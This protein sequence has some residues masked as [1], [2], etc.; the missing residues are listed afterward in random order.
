MNHFPTSSRFSSC[1]PWSL[2][3]KLSFR[4][5]VKN[6]YNTSS[7]HTSRHKSSKPDTDSAL[8]HAETCRLG[9]MTFLSLSLSE[10]IFVSHFGRAE[11]MEEWGLEGWAFCGGSGK[12]S[13]ACTFSKPILRV[14]S[15]EMFYYANSNMWKT[16]KEDNQDTP[17]FRL[18]VNLLQKYGR[19]PPGKQKLLKSDVSPLELVHESSLAFSFV[20]FVVVVMEREFWQKSCLSMCFLWKSKENLNFL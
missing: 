13:H 18:C 17:A 10:V 5:W 9:Y 4:C 8:V 11:K 14:L 3:Q 20:C 7:K 16:V 2:E 15:W 12:Q 1:Q 6:N 19:M